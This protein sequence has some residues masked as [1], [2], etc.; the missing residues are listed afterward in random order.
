MTA[1]A[2]LGDHGGLKISEGWWRSGHR[3][4]RRREVDGRVECVPVGMSEGKHGAHG[5]FSIGQGK[6][7]GRR[8]AEATRCTR[9]E[10]GKGE[11]V[12]VCLGHA[13]QRRREWGGGLAAGKVCGQR[14]RWSVGRLP[15]EAG[16]RREERGVRARGPRSAIVGRP[17]EEDG[18]A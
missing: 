6:I 10:E 9:E 1:A 8:G 15:C 16:E 7:G 5:G 14:R 3:R 2:G 12:G 4:R 17:R 18:R 13:T 11:G